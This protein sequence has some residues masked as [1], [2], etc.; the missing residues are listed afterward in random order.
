MVGFPLRYTQN[1]QRTE[2]KTVGVE[3]AAAL[4]LKSVSQRSY[5]LILKKFIS[6]E[7]SQ[8]ALSNADELLDG[9][10]VCKKSVGVK[11]EVK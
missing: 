3:L 6:G 8:R 5:L 10:F 7:S 4:T 11:V 2:P 1:L 9:W